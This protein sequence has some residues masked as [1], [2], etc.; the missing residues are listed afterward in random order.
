MMEELGEFCQAIVKEK[1]HKEQVEELADILHTWCC[2]AHQI[3]IT[4]QDI[5]EKFNATSLRRVQKLLWPDILV[6]HHI[7]HAR[8][9]SKIPT[10]SFK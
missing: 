8:Y 6:L 4:D 9:S 5:V 2:I 3:G 7:N 10:G 1:T